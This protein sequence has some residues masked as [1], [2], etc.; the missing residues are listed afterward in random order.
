MPPELVHAL[1]RSAGRAWF[2]AQWRLG[3]CR[4]PRRQH[5]AVARPRHYLGAGDS[6]LAR[7]C[8]SGGHRPYGGTL[9]RQHCGRGLCQ[10]RLRP[11]LG[12]SERGL[13]NTAM[14]APWPSTRAI[15]TA[16][17][18]ASAKDRAMAAMCR[19]SSTFR[20][21]PAAPGLGRLPAFPRPRAISTPSIS[22]LTP[23]G[24]LGSAVEDQ[25][26]R[27]EDRGESWSEFWRAPAAIVAVA[28]AHSNGI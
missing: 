28:C 16:C 27:S 8:A 17:W 6:G 18:P 23:R 14:A 19:A 1:G 21:T 3:F 10:R 24:L 2:G 26:Y 9:V 20:T 5:H 13:G 22:P 12:A 4:Y 7:G 25:L 11:L 15:P